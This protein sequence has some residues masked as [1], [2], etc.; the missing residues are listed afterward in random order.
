MRHEAEYK[1][2]LVVALTASQTLTAR[3][4]GSL[5]TNR[6]AAG[7]VIATLPTGQKG[8]RFRFLRIAAQS[9][10][11]N[12]QNTE[13]LVDE[14]GTTLTAGFT[15]ELGSTGAYLEYEHDGTAWQQ[16]RERGTINNET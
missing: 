6:G 9:F 16:L 2:N 1:T 11:V 10:K 12:P 7:A 4:S 14:D 13:S 3:H 5:I 15:Q 8:L